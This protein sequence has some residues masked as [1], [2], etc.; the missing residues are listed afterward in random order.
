MTLSPREFHY[1]NNFNNELWEFPSFA[2]H[3]T[4]TAPMKTAG[5]AL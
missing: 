5:N 2:Y 4:A 1:T 3:K